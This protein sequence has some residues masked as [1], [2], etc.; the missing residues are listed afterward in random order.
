MFEKHLLNKKYFYL[1][2]WFAFANRGIFCSIL[3]V[4]IIISAKKTETIMVGLFAIFSTKL[5]LSSRLRDAAAIPYAI[6]TKFKY[7]LWFKS[8]VGPDIK[9]Y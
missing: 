2:P 4:S 9:F 3:G 8:S 6:Y 7:F 1:F 5:R